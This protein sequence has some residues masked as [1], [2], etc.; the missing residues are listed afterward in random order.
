M[1]QSQR[2]QLLKPPELIA[3]RT[4][5]RKLVSG[6]DREK[7]NGPKCREARHR[8]SACENEMVRRYCAAVESN[9]L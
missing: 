4:R 8:L 9:P 2:L 6:F 7:D 3:E 1:K 5:Q